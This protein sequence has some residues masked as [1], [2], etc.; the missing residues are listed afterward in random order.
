MGVMQTGVVQTGLSPVV[1][2][3]VSKTVYTVHLY[4]PPTYNHWAVVIVKDPDLQ[5]GIK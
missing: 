5:S 3:H 1:E 4:K 2:V